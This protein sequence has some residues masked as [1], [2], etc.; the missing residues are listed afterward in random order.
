[1]DLGSWVSMTIDSDGRLIIAREANG[2]LRLTLS[3]EG[4][5]IESTEWIN[6][7]LKECR[8]L[9]FRGEELF[10]NAN[11]SKGLYRLRPMGD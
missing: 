1:M 7:D 11:N 9:T 6:R 3:P 4:D 2:L 5:S 8:G 10:A